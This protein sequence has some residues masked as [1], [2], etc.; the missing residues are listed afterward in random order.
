L[1]NP[2][3]NWGQE[4]EKPI[5]VHVSTGNPKFDPPGFGGTQ[6]QE[7]GFGLTNN[8]LWITLGWV[9]NCCLLKGFN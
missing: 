3:I 6:T 2:L 1:G 7:T 8:L 9:R 5:R 4:G